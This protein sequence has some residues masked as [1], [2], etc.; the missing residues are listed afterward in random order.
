MVAMGAGGLVV[1]LAMAGKP[2]KLSFPR[3]I[4]IRLS[5]AL[6]LGSRQ[7]VILQVL[8]ILGSSNA[9]LP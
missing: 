1:A 2:F 9:A 7:D 6:P 5:G 8:A 3:V 4:G